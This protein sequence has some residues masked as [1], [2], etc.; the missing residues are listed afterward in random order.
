[1]RGKFLWTTSSCPLASSNPSCLHAGLILGLNRR[2]D[3][4][5]LSWILNVDPQ[6]LFHAALLPKQVCLGKNPVARMLDH[7]YY[8]VA[9][10]LI[11]LPK[12]KNMDPFSI[13]RIRDSLTSILT[14]EPNEGLDCCH[15]LVVQLRLTK[16]ISKLTQFLNSINQFM[17]TTRSS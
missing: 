3:M 13:P 9:K 8:K 17:N 11:L 10:W 6:F 5:N 4:Y 15:A 1:M 12:H 2:S 14:R 7:W 16:L